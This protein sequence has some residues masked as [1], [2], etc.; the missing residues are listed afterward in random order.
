VGAPGIGLPSFYPI[1]L[2]QISDRLQLL[3][4]TANGNV[5][6]RYNDLNL[7]AKG[8]STDVSH[9]YNNISQ[10]SGAFGRGWSMSTGADVGLEISASKV[11]LHG[12]TGYTTTFTKNSN[13]SY[14]TGSG[15]NSTSPR[16]GTAP[17]R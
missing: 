10:G 7:G 15:G 3:V 4:D 9:V 8:F 14:T 2:R 11:I 6:V 17:G 12:P 13:G 5:V 16:P 1:E